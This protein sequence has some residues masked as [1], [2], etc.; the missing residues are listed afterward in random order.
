VLACSVLACS[1]LACLS[2]AVCARL[3]VWNACQLRSVRLRADARMPA[4]TCLQTTL[5]TLPHSVLKHCR[6]HS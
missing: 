4:R 2:A 6:A 1:V 3:S 5:E